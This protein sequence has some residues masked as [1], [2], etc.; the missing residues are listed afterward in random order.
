MTNKRSPLATA[1]LWAATV[2]AA[3]GLVET[4]DNKM[5][6]HHKDVANNMGEQ[7][8]GAGV[9]AYILGKRSPG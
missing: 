6:G 3:C 2:A 5:F 7:A 8:I 1:F 4:A 9:T